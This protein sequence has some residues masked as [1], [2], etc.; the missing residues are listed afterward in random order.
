MIGGQGQQEEPWRLALLK[1]LV[2]V[3]QNSP[4]EAKGKG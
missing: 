1:R 2:D 3:D 4:G